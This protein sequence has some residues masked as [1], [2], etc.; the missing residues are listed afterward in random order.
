MVVGQ[1]FNWD[2]DQWT[3]LAMEAT[4][5]TIQSR[6]GRTLA[7]ATREFVH[8]LPHGEP[9]DPWTEVEGIGHLIG[10]MGV[11]EQKS[12]EQRLNDVNEVL[13][14]FKSGNPAIAAVDEPRSSY[15]PEQPMMSRYLAKAEERG[16]HVITIRR[17]VKNYR[18]NGASGLIDERCHRSSNPFG[19]V[20]E[21]WLDTARSVLS[22]HVNAS[23]P[24][25]KTIVTRVNERVQIVFG[26]GIV[27]N[28]GRATALKVLDE[29]ARG[30]NDFR[31][32]TKQKRSIA[33]RPQGTYGHL[34]ATRPGEYLMVDTTPLDVFGLDRLTNRWTRCE[35]TVAM[36]VYSRCITAIRLTPS[37]K[38][39]DAALLLYEAIT[40]DPFQPPSIPSLPYLGLPTQ[41]AV[42]AE[43]I[44]SERWRLPGVALETLVVDHGK[45]FLSNHLFAVCDRLGVSI[46]PARKYTPTDK[47]PV[48]RWFRTLGEGL[49]STLP[50]Y[51]GPDVSSRALATEDETFYAIDQLEQIIREWI[52]RIYHRRPHRG[53]CLPE[54]PGVDLSPQEAFQYG[55]ARA[56]MLRIPESPFLALDFLPVVWR[57]IQHYGVDVKG[58]RF[59]SECLNHLRDV[60]SPHTGANPGKWPFR[61]DPDDLSTL[62]F[63][64]PQTKCWHE[65]PWNR[66]NELGLPFSE[67]A[68]FHAREMSK[69][70]D[71]PFDEVAVLSKLLKRWE[72]GF[73]KNP[74]ERRMA[75]RSDV[76][77]QPLN[78]ARYQ[79]VVELT[80]VAVQRALYP[81][82]DD[83]ASAESVSDDDDFDEAP[84]DF[85][86]GALEVMR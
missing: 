80:P 28:P 1:K 77:R 43:R 39:I 83:E 23:R 26:E 44:E 31:G 12:F 53:L 21:R 16:V 47:A 22:E 4:V 5:V 2:G 35:L 3:I 42:D 32:A 63:Q 45:I 70:G 82:T 27:K 48:E 59:N 66:R 13:T 51:K 41:V 19:K 76:K 72:A 30:R 71:L 50:G 14:G 61:Y 64:D 67:E 55:L 65:V 57:T 33:N 40:T 79:E 60:R 7:I 11:D 81:M 69:D 68:L 37:T 86:G 75:I 9:T 78:E 17:W 85:Y 46:Q 29:I 62:Y 24:T 20:D 54:V 38:S 74:A 25:K 56:G 6:S 52:I 36:D 84:D 58:L 15:A 49:L 18:E 8:L 34:V 10:N 73:H